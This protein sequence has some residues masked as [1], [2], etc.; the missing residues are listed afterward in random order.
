LL[1]LGAADEVTSCCR[2]LTE[3]VA[4]GGGFILDMGVAADEGKD[5]NMRAMIQAAKDYG[6]C[7]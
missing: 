4:P 2:K 3:A 5:A 7:S 1:Q 6:V